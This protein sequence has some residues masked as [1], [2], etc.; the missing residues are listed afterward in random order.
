MRRQVRRALTEHGEATVVV[1]ASSCTDALD[2]MSEG[3]DLRVV[4][5]VTFAVERLLPHLE[6]T[7]SLPSLVLHPTC[8]STRMDINDDLMTVA[9]FISDEVTVPP[10]WS[11]CGFAGD[12][13]LLHPEL[14]AS[15]TRDE[16][17]EVRSGFFAYAS[18][19]RT[20]EIAMSRATGRTYVHLLEL[21]AQATR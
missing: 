7:R 15:A 19:N 3:L 5:V 6:V 13:G 10:S 18:L 12:R 21:L 8:A 4:D 1:D 16:A 2:R 20:C 11:C 17:A 9:R 14:T